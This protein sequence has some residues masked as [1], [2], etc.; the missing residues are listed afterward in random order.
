MSGRRNGYLQI[1]RTA[2]SIVKGN[3]TTQE[4]DVIVN[5]TNA[6][7]KLDKAGP[8]SKAILSAA[9]NSIQSECDVK[10]PFNINPGDVAITGPGYLEALKIF[11]IYLPRYNDSEDEKYIHT[12]LNVCLKKADSLG[13]QSIAFPALGTGKL[14][15]NP[16][17]VADAL[18]EAVE[19]YNEQNHNPKLELVICVVYQD[20]MYENFVAAA[21]RR[22]RLKGNEA[23]GLM[24]RTSGS[25]TLGKTTVKVMVGDLTQKQADVLVHTCSH[26]L[27]LNQT[28]GLS[29]AVLKAAGQNIQNEIDD[30]YDGTLKNGEFVVTNGYGLSCKKVYHGKVLCFTANG[31]NAKPDEVLSKFVKNCLT[32]AS[33]YC[34]HS[35]AFPA[36]GTGELKFPSDISASI[37]IEAIRDFLHHHPQTTISD[38]KIVIYGGNITW[39]SIEKAYRNELSRSQGTPNQ[40]IQAV[41]QRGSKAY[42][43][44]KY[45]EEPRPPSN[46]SHF[47]CNK[48]I[49]ELLVK[50]SKQPFKLV[51]PDNATFQSIKHLFLNTIG[52]NCAQV[53]SIMRNENLKVFEKYIQDCQRLFCRAI[54]NGPCKSLANTPRSRGSVTTLQYVNRTIAHQLNQDLNEVYLFHGTKKERVDALLQNGLDPRLAALNFPTLWLGSGVYAAEE[55]SLSA[56]YTPPDG[57]GVCTMFVMRVCLGDVFTTQ[58]KMQHLRRPPCKELCQTTCIQHNEFFD[59]VVGEFQQREFVVYDGAKCYPEYVIE[60]KV[61]Q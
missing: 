57:Q 33:R 28:T 27:Q 47:E 37:L 14:N 40:I 30:S 61:L 25:K 19:R 4:I 59:S 3:I 38:I 7:L 39:S 6:E 45:K 36:I 18:F 8:S 50:H 13:H 49:K 22:A 1:G 54:S 15:Y 21:R 29:T 51:K 34:T 55:A 24:E 10:Y 52:I 56:K 43:R 31:E 23:R 26:N 17:V 35:I 12:A 44:Y 16:N 2:V 11:H 58:N 5:T 42:F 53:V 9:G 60:Y 20:Q 48:T 46:W 32:T 41:P